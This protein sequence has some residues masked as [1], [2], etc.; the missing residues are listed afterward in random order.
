MAAVIVTPTPA[1]GFISVGFTSASADDDFNY[2]KRDGLYLSRTITPGPPFTPGVSSYG[3]Y[4]VPS[5]ATVI[6]EGN[7]IQDGQELAPTIIQT[8]L[9]LTSAW[10]HHVAKND[11]NNLGDLGAIE[12]INL[13][14]QRQTLT[15]ESDALRLA[16]VEKPKIKS[17]QHNQRI[18][19]CPIFIDRANRAA[20]MPLLEEIL[21]SNELFLFRDPDG[22]FMFCT[23]PS[24]E[25][26]TGMHVNMNLVLWESAYSE[27]FGL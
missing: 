15:R 22:A 25:T 21:W 12:L 10:I 5:G 3:D 8:S 24:Q 23:I 16:A 18:I 13:Q 19:E 11:G 4:N 2:L 7:S 6:Y 20:V 27:E 14:G 9:T 17:S 26:R 1:S